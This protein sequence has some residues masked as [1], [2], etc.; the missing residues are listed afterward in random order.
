MKKYP[1]RIENLNENGYL[2]VKIPRICHLEG[3]GEEDGYFSFR[4]FVP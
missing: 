4:E 3:K 2:P 1:F